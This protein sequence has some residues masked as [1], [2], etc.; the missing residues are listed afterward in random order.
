[1]LHFLD[2]LFA[3][4]WVLLDVYWLANCAL[5]SSFVSTERIF[6]LIFL[7]L[8]LSLSLSRLESPVLDYLP[9]LTIGCR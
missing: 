3:G 7:F 4:V 1:M 9:T 2:L 6:Q 5:Q 8:S